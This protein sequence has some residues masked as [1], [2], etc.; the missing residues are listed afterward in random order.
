MKEVLEVHRQGGNKLKNVRGQSTQA[1]ETD[2]RVAGEQL[3]DG[4]FDADG[5]L[6][7]DSEDF[8]F[9]FG[10]LREGGQLAVRALDEKDVFGRI[11]EA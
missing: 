1:R 5:V 10:F 9:A 7:A 2:V 6:A 4:L 3:H 8:Q 11:A